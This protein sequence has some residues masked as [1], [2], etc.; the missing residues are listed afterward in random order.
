MRELDQDE[1]T[2]ISAGAKASPGA[3]AKI[4]ALAGEAKE[5]CVGFIEGVKKGYNA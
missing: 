2:E 3:L 1:I 5:F 4:I